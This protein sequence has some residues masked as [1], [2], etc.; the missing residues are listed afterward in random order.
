MLQEKIVKTVAI[1]NVD[2]TIIEKP[3]TLYAGFHSVAP[4][5]ESEGDWGD[6]YNR[7]QKRHREIIDSTTPE[8]MITLSIGYNE[9]H[10][11]NNPDVILEA[12]HGKET[13]NPNQPEGIKVIEAPA[14]F[15]IRVKWSE[16]T[17][18]LVKKITDSQR[19]EHMSPFFGLMGALFCKPEHEFTTEGAGNLEME[20][21]HFD[22]SKYAAIP[23]QKK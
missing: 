23:V 16:E 3:K 20:Y 14:C 7:F 10:R 13:T 2:F 9:K 15:L 1:D 11:F 22:G 19:Y 6:T 4:D 17:W 21:Y 18:A 8:C 5:S 12:F